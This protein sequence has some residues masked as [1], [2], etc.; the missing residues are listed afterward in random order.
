MAKQSTRWI[1]SE[2]GNIQMKWSGSCDACQR[3]NTFEETIETKESKKRFIAKGDMSS[4]PVLIKDV[5]LQGFDRIKTGWVELDRLMGGGVVCG[6]LTL[7]G[8][9]PGVGKSTLML[10]LAYAFAKQG[11][12]ILYVCGEESAEQTSMRAKR[13]D[14]HSDRL[15]LLHETLFSNIKMHIDHL[16]PDLLIIDSAQIIYKEEIPSAPGSVV[17]VKEVAMECMHLAKGSKITTFLIGH[18]TKSGDLAGP[19]VLEHIVDTVLDF[20]GD[21]QHGYRLLRSTKNR[22]GQT[23]D[24]V[25][26]QMDTTGLKEVCN[27]SLVFLEERRK[28]SPGSVIASMLEGSRSLLVEVQALVT[29]SFYPTPTRRSMGI[30]QNRFAILLAVLE[31]RMRYPLYTHDVFVS[32]MGGV[33]ALEPAVDLAVLL[34]IVSSYQTKA[35]S[36]KTAVMGEVG[37]SGEIRSVIRIEN[38]IKEAIHM[39]F[40]AC[41]IPKKN[42]NGLPQGLKEKIELRVVDNVEEAI[43]VLFGE[44][45][46]PSR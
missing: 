24:I 11:L 27:P 20:E 1:C 36:G 32:V 17:Q 43:E 44:L 38:R 14:I 9:Q 25:V 13:L 46:I 21:S 7:V 28:E 30:D 22:F 35:L 3:W 19:R 42:E 34:A 33:K 18:V 2:C 45:C 31:K 15:Y 39:G 8:G 26:F 16:K 6:S 41:V 5:S 12:T 29:R 40:D 37:L 4:K 10:Q 23:D